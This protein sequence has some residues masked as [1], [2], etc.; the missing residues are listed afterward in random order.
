MHLA[1]YTLFHTI[2]WS[3][4]CDKLIFHPIS[5]LFIGFSCIITKASKFYWFSCTNKVIWTFYLILFYPTSTNIFFGV[6]FS[7]SQITTVIF[8]VEQWIQACDR[9]CCEQMVAKW[10]QFIYLMWKQAN[11]CWHAYDS[12]YVSIIPLFYHWAI[13]AFLQHP[14]CPPHR[15]ILSTCSFCDLRFRGVRRGVW[16]YCQMAG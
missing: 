2:N 1:L 11:P 8:H 10:V 13:A 5:L 14:L 6:M 12:F 7:I 15:S 16:I 9:Q 3:W 4:W